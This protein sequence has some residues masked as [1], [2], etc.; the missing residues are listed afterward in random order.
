MAKRQQIGAATS[1]AAGTPMCSM[2]HHHGRPGENVYEEILEGS[3]RYYSI[4]PG[5]RYE[6]REL[7]KYQA[8]TSNRRKKKKQ[9]PITTTS[10][11]SS[12]NKN[13]LIDV[14]DEV[15]KIHKRHDRILGEL[16][17]DVEAMIMPPRKNSDDVDNLPIGPTDELLSPEC[18]YRSSSV[19]P[20]QQQ[21]RVSFDTSSYDVPAS[22][23]SVKSRRSGSKIASPSFLRKRAASKNHKQL[24]DVGDQ[25]LV[26]L[27]PYLE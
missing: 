6:D 5:Q 14:F 8:Q 3:D 22:S 23:S 13:I 21:Q 1:S 2:L 25:K 19:S 9:Y 27:V 7:A 17:L 11:S 16:N 26:R 18:Q 10:T 20:Q 15:K 4:G 24:N 12:K